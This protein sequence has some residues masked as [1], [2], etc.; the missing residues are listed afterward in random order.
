MSPM[1]FRVLAYSVAMIFAFNVQAIQVY[2]QTSGPTFATVPLRSDTNTA[3]IELDFK[4]PDGSPRKA[5]FVVDTGGGAFIMGAQL[6]KDLALQQVG[7][8]RETEDGHGVQSAAPKVSMGGMDLDLSG[9]NT[10]ISLD[11]NRVDARDDSEGLMPS[12]VLRKYHV[13]F[14]YPAN[15]FTL[16]K[17]G[18]IKPAGERFSAPLGRMG[19]PRIALTI[20]GETQGYL[21]D[22]G[23][24]YTMISQETLKS[25]SAAHKDW[26]HGTGATG[27]ANMFGGNIENNAMMMRFP[28]AQWGSFQ[29]DNFAAVSRPNGTFETN[30]SRLMSTPIVGAIGGNVLKLF[31]IEIDY[32]NSAVYLQKKGA[33]EPHDLDVIGLTLRADKYGT[34]IVSGVC[35]TAAKETSNAVKQGDKLIR[36]DD[37]E[38]MGQ[39]LSAIQKRLSGKVGD[40]KTLIIIRNGQQL[41]VKAIVARLL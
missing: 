31:R 32:A 33:V 14:D 11:A 9:V 19:F 37:F 20:G 10:V 35:E 22:T 1:S 36:V 23:A 16:A 6:A 38:A 5:K 34:I 21:L 3:I 25:W 4:R 18:S 13:I 2:A 26:P 12:S 27:A 8:I 39:P 41:T 29:L 40:T 24:T 15:E 17:P 7:P 30:M 28:N